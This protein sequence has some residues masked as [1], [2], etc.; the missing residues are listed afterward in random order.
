MCTDLSRRVV[1][2]SGKAVEVGETLQ[3]FVT[4]YEKT[5][6][7]IPDAIKEFI[8]SRNKDKALK[9]S[10]TVDLNLYGISDEI[11]AAIV[12]EDN[13]IWVGTKNGM[14]RIDLTEQDDRDKVQYFIGARYFYDNN[15]S[16][17]F[18][19]SDRNKGVWVLTETGVSHIE[20]KPMSYTEKAIL[21]SDNTQ[22]NVNRRGMVAN[23]RLVDGKWIPSPS[24]NDG[25]W[26][27]MYAAGEC[28]RYAVE[29]DPERKEEARR[30][31]T[32]AVEAVL[33]LANISAR[34]GQIDAKIRHF[35]NNYNEMSKEYVRKGGDPAYL[36][37]EKGPVGKKLEELI[38]P[39]DHRPRTPEDW[40][41]EGEA[42]TQK[43]TLK[44]FVARSYHL[45][46]L[47]TE[48]VPK[49]GGFFF[50]KMRKN[51][52]M[53][54]KAL[55]FDPGTGP[56]DPA[57]SEYIKVNK[58]AK[59]VED[60]AG[61][62]VDASL[63]IPARLA[64]LY[65]SV[66]KGDGTYYTDED[67]IY[68]AD[69]S[70]DELIG[71]LFVYKV[72]YDTLCAGEEGDKELGE[73]IKNTSR[74]LAQHLLDNDYCLVDATGQP[75]LW[76]KMNRAYFNSIFT[77]DDC[78]LNCLVLLC[79]IK[80]AA[81]LTG[82][83]KWEEEYRKL[84]LEEPYR[85]ADLAGEYR[86]RYNK[87]AV[88]MYRRKNPEAPANSPYLDPN[89]RETAME[90]QRILNYSDEEMAM[91]AYYVLFQTE[92]DPVLLE[93][94][95]KGI[96]SWW[97]SIQYS[98][99]PLWFYIYQLAYPDSVGKVDLQTAAWAL[100]RH[101]ID[102]RVWYVDNSVRHDIVEYKDSNKAMS[103]DPD[104]WFVSLPMDEK[105]MRKYNA[106]PFEMKGGD[107][108]GERLEGS[109]TYTLPYWLGRFHGMIKEKENR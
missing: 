36:Y 98:N 4:R 26:T 29:T 55:P 47:E 48:P 44:G 22:K 68:K 56:E 39:E 12:D 89:S 37:P 21:M 84:A 109:T 70:T 77:W 88:E 72:A 11:T 24:D 92:T 30:I 14:I 107:E 96:D 100:K 31:A 19:L 27:S 46:G 103:K 62:E 105:P 75:T 38:D 1:N 80:L 15:S 74:N 102:T 59:E 33:L 7:N 106:C 93:K 108:R 5:D 69:T 9:A 23:S 73:I 6:E 20:M 53:I 86:D 91:L 42:E 16:V 67:V 51:G 64:N 90:V 54:A 8:A 10:P 104:G 50:K 52:K 95:R 82:E 94:Y 87:L 78:S 17:E 2:Y 3:K 63:E 45:D 76:G 34:D 65:R 81:Y 71:H 43:R 49:G 35:I 66:P 41:L 85:Y 40:V 83:K 25:L 61:I 99:N 60:F 97:I 58:R 32:R 13:V 57:R 79:A 101:P 18:I 28:F